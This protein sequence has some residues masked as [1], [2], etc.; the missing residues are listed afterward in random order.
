VPTT[1][2]YI[3]W[4]DH[5]DWNLSPPE[6]PPVPGRA[7]R[8]YEAAGRRAGDRLASEVARTEALAP[9]RTVT[10]AAAYAVAVGFHGTLAALVVGGIGLAVL[11]FP[12]PFAIFAGV[13][14]VGVAVAM[15]PR[16]GKPPTDGVVSEADAPRLHALVAEVA[17]AVGTRVDVL[18][19]DE[20]FNASWAVLGIRRRRVL[21]LGLPLLTT[22]DPGERVALLAHELAHA[23]NRDATR[24]LVVGSAVNG[25]GELYA[26][27]APD[28]YE[29]EW[30]LGAFDPIANVIGWI[31]SR[32]VL[33][34]LY[35]EL[36][37]LARDT[38]RAEY[39]AD[40][41][42][43]RTAGTSAVV[44]VHEQLLLESFF[45]ASLK[46]AATERA[47]PARDLLL[48]LREKLRSV[49]D[50]ERERRR[51]IARLT[52]ARL[53]DTHPPTAKRIEVLESRPHQA[54]RVTLSREGSATIDDE[55]AARRAAVAAELVERYREELYAAF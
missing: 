11:A 20:G 15:R 4:C 39:L 43:A 55:L 29:R 41:L 53:G 9:R 47:A 2:G 17:E 38:R 12:N 36:H 42:A 26:L 22:L 48:E 8:L 18:V 14:L 34:V 51:R 16:L 6:T 21:T 27:L 54:P 44:S 33:A 31:L 25:L 32:P 40:W 10:R 5:C 28:P 30:S 13:V 1:P 45:D 52:G 19:V 50:H 23:R 7:G 49:P 37:L 3:A 46:R 24:G 35:V